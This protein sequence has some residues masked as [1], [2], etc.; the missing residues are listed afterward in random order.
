MTPFA[1]IAS[2]LWA[3]ADSTPRPAPPTTIAELEARVRRVLDTTRTP[4]VGLVIVRRD[5]VI[6][7]N[8]LGNARV[9]PARPATAATLFRIGSTSK[10]F[11]ALTALA[12]EREGKLS[13]NDPVRKHLPGF[14]YRN[15]WEAT[16]TLRIVHL[17]EHTSGFDDNSIKA[18]A[19]N[20]PT[21]LTLERGLALDSATRVS[22]WR[23]GTRFSYCNTGPAIVARIAEVIE[24]KPFEQI[25]QER[26]F[27]PIGMKTA[28]YFRPDSARFD[29]VTLYRDDG[30]TPVRYWNVFVR[31]AG[32]INASAHDMGAYLR[33]LLGRGSIDGRS[34]LPAD[35]IARAER[36][37]S[38]I[39][40]RDGLS[41]GYGLH[42]YQQADSLGFIWTGHNGGVEGGISDL[43]Y[44]PDDSVGYAF[45]TN[46]ANGAAVSEITSLVRSFVT[47]GL[48][49][50]AAPPPT[51][52]V[53]SSIRQSFSGWYRP[54]S[55]RIQAIA[56]FERILGLT[57]VTVSDSGLR[58]APVLGGATDYLAV[59]SLRFRQRGQAV[60]TLALTRDAANG[61][62]FGMDGGSLGASSERIGAASA[63]VQIGIAGLWLCAVA[64]SLIAMVFGAVRWMVRRVRHR[65][66]TPATA[67]PLWRTAAVL[68]ALLLVH[69]ICLQLARSDLSAFGTV[70]PLSVGMVLTGILFAVMALLGLLRALR[71]RP[72]T[73]R[74]D[75]LSVLTAR[76]ALVLYSIVAAYAVVG[77]YIGWRPWA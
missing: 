65:T 41:L 14:Y 66:Q 58:V 63:I 17:L 49:P 64:L 22:R 71:R 4:G 18:Y 34:L 61:R 47:H 52:R 13:L 29:V 26:W 69:L 57:Q 7:A 2:I 35:A 25:V 5:S 77:R 60:A 6:Y 32:S 67:A 8:G 33:F 50:R 55:P 1:L 72:T 74:W 68:T 11:V 20:D 38:W 21:P 53:S 9:A 45:Q 19:N 70:S 27:D 24:G 46:T 15:P 23:P 3:A 62:A 12:L 73:S 28:T 75:Q 36:P 43:S 51:G 30:Q 42:L 44:L 37:A 59:D 54:V 10:A 16:D 39:G 31:P 56:L 40:I 48:R 76:S